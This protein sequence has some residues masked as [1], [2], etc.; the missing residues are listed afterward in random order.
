MDINKQLEGIV[1]SM[2]ADIRVK[3]ESD[4]KNTVNQTVTNKIASSELATLVDKAVKDHIN[5]KVEQFNFEE[6]GKK[7][8]QKIVDDLTTQI[9]TNLVTSINQQVTDGINKRLENI[10]IRSVA[11]DIVKDQ[12]GKIVEAK[13]FKDRSINHT[14]INFANLVLTGDHI[15]GGIIENFGSTGIEDLATHVQMTLMDHAVAFEGPVYAP[16]AQIK[17]NLKIEGD[18]VITGSVDASQKGFDNIVYRARDEVRA[19]LNQELFNTFSETVF[20]KISREG[21]DLDRITQNGKEVI[22]GTQLGYHIT[23]SNL[24]KLGL[25]VDLQTTGENLLVNTLYVSK[26]RVGINTMDPGSAFTVVDGEVEVNVYKHAANTA[27]IGTPR[28]QDVILGSNLKQNIVL[29][30]DGGVTVQK[31]TIGNSKHSAAAKVPNQTGNKGDIV[32]NSEPAVGS[33]IGWVC[34]GGTRWASFGTIS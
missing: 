9:N 10:D 19:S 26:G 5:K 18:L 11:H 2:I 16:E 20:G 6:V 31:L 28:R 34:L 21:I 12:L 24:T 13:Q 15:K 7:N 29:D 33:S 27:Y 22:R 8:L 4:V 25:V 14:A 32:W 30:Q 17:G 3:I 1:S 23:Q